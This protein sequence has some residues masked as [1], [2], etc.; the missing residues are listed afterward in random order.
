MPTTLEQIQEWADQGRLHGAKYLV[1]RCS[2]Y[3]QDD[4]EHRYPIFAKS[5][6]ERQLAISTGEGRFEA[7][8]DLSIDIEKQY[9][10]TQ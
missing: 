4:G 9:E 8:F 10:E 3:D 6:D 1:V 5:D 7:V 2:R